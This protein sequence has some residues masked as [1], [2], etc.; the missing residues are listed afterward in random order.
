MLIEGQ[1]DPQRE[2]VRIFFGIWPDDTAQK[3]LAALAE[4]LQAE[5]LCRGRKTAQE[6]IHLTL[7][8]VGVVDTRELEALSLAVDGVNGANV[9]AFDVVIEELRYW[10][11]NGIAY[12]AVARIPQE[13]KDLVDALQDALSAAGFSTERRAYKPHI[14]LMRAAS[15]H[16]LP[17]LADPIAWQAREWI[18]VKSKQTSAGSVYTPIGRWPLI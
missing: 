15:C 1:P 9:G 4:R 11:H 13:L 18:L 12:A 6:N 16:S 17:K 2:T 8:F 7:V 10:K 3:K 5:S 14:T